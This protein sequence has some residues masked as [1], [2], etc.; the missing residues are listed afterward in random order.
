MKK[1]RKS[2]HH[3]SSRKSRAST[4]LKVRKD[5]SPKPPGATVDTGDEQQFH[6][7]PLQKE[8][9]QAP[10][11]IGSHLL[12]NEV[13]KSIEQMQ[14]M[15]LEVQIS[16]NEVKDLQGRLKAMEEQLSEMKT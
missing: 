1:S 8:M 9:T 7:S 14:N 6:E 11:D 3:R 16:N 15:K 4:T 2:T 10:S 5:K 13:N 12:Q